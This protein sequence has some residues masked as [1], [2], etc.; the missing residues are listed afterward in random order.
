MTCGD[1]DEESENDRDPTEQFILE[2]E[3]TQNIDGG[4]EQ[5][6]NPRQQ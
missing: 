2:D 4:E 5:P 3:V 1:L 6:L